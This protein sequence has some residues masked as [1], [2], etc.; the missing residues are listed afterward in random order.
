MLDVAYDTHFLNDLMTFSI[1]CNNSLNIQNIDSET[2]VSGFH[3]SETG[4]TPIAWYFFTSLKI[5]F[6]K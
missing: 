5:N 2:L 3:N 1:G 6:I 4:D